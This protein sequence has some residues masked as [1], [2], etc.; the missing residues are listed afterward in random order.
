MWLLLTEAIK[1]GRLLTC[2][3]DP[4]FPAKAKRRVVFPELGGPKSNAILQETGSIGL[5]LRHQYSIYDVSLVFS[6]SRLNDATNI[7]K[8]W[9]WLLSAGKKM[10]I[11]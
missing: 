5:E 6:P 11:V 8:Y 9:Q 10:E 4:S 7:M 2:R 1:V 3:S